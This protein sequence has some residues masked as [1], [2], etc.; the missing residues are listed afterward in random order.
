[1]IGTRNENLTEIISPDV[2]TLGLIKFL[3]HENLVIAIYNLE[4]EVNLLLDF[5]INQL[6]SCL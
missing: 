6:T 5:G 4:R 3:F 2:R 1:M